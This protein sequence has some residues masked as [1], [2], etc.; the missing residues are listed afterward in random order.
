MVR[1]RGV[2]GDKSLE[3]ERVTLGVKRDLKVTPKAEGPGPSQIGA[4][5]CPRRRE[6][7]VLANASRNHD[8]RLRGTSSVPGSPS[9]RVACGQGS[10]LRWPELEPCLGSW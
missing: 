1:V 4:L 9:C 7:S 5:R 6:Y 10:G 8:Q 2:G 3:R